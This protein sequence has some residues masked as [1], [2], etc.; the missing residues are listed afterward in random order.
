MGGKVLKF[1][2]TNVNIVAFASS[3]KNLGDIWIYTGHSQSRCNDITIKLIPYINR[4][5]IEDCSLRGRGTARRWDTTSTDEGGQ[6]ESPCVD[7][8]ED[9]LQDLRRKLR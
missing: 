2:C 3:L 9:E 6:G 8:R 7:R 5:C 4:L 1:N